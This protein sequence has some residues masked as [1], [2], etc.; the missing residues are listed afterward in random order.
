MDQQFMKVI[1]E[2]QVE[3][4]KGLKDIVRVLALLTQIHERQLQVSLDN[5]GQ[6]DFATLPADVQEKLIKQFE[7]VSEQEKQENPADEGADSDSNQESDSD[8][9]EES[10]ETDEEE[11][12]GEDTPK[13]E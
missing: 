8:D 3:Q 6:I 11:N 9:S 12:T 4:T 5:L 10:D 1:I 13:E 2:N 7:G